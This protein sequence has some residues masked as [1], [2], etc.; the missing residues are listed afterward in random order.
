M[1]IALRA[2]QNHLK[3]TAKVS[4]YTLRIKH[5][6]IFLLLFGCSSNEQANSSINIVTTEFGEISLDSFINNY[7]DFLRF[8]GVEDNLNFRAGL[9]NSEIDR[10]YLLHHADISG[11]RNRPY[12]SQKLKSVRLQTLLNEFYLREIDSPFEV[13]IEDTR[14]A[15]RRTKVQIHARHLY[16]PTIEGAEE[17]KRKLNRGKSFNELAAEI[18]QDPQLAGNGGDLGFFTF[19]EMDPAFE[20]VAY[21][22]KDGEISNPVKTQNGFSIIQ[23]IERVY[24]PIITEYDYQVHREDI[25][26]ILR[27]RML[28]DEVKEYTSTIHSQLSLEIS[29]DDLELLFSMFADII[30]NSVSQDS[31]LRNIHI[32]TATFSWNFDEI[33]QALKATTENQRMQVQSPDDLYM[34]LSGLCVRKE[35]F[36]RIEN[37]NWR[38]DQDVEQTI[39]EAENRRVIR[40]LIDQINN[41]LDNPE[42]LNESRSAY[43]AFIKILRSEAEASI[44]RDLLKSFIL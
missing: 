37:A 27:Q 10:L 42:D 16:S 3:L 35:L 30:S 14:E 32:D 34:M 20:E 1:Y 39:N 6:A 2:K 31:D 19:N 18:F 40:L 22:L 29:S 25:E 23:V 36:K 24:E 21:A 17:L 15:F 41:D 43:F 13:S 4:L 7:N 26:I 9:L 8:T 28:K 38:N 12:I 33:L 11:F 44:D 5:A